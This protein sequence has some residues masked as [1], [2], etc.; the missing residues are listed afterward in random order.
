MPQDCLDSMLV[1]GA[2]ARSRH[3]SGIQRRV[4]EKTHGA[5][6]PRPDSCWRTNQTSHNDAAGIEYLTDSKV[7]AVD[8]K[9]KTLKLANGG[10]DI[11]YDKFIIATG[12]TVSRYLSSGYLQALVVV[13]K[14]CGIFLSDG[15]VC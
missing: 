1:L 8:V 10:E 2:G 14:A 15:I 7:D 12:S 6:A 13:E 5:A 11:T 4:S 9:S 3:L